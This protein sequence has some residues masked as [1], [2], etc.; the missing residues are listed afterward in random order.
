MNIKFGPAGMNN[1]FLLEKTN[2][3]ISYPSY[4]GNLNLDA[5][6]Y[7][8]GHGIR[9]SQKMANEFGQE[10]KKNSI[11]ISIHSPYYISLSSIEPQK[12]KNS[13]KYI[14]QTAQ[15]AKAMG[16]KRIVVHSGSCSKISRTHA[17]DL[18][19]DTINQ[20]LLT[21][22]NENLD[23]IIICPEVMGKTNQL[24]TVDE[25]IELS[26]LGDNVIPCVDFGHLNARSFGTLKSKS[27]YQI[28]FDKIENNLGNFKMKNLH[29]HFSKIEYTQPG[30]E[31]RHLTFE[32]KNFGPDFH[33]LAEILIKKS[34][35]PIIICESAGTQ[36]EDAI[37]MKQIYHCFLSKI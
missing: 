9:I 1:A 23:D 2:K 5:Y 32:D 22:K 31:K 24:G 30:G 13:V 6:E 10:C 27:D 28:V 11:Y 33:P 25:V 19:K 20:A 7:Q 16:A 21:L 14:L 36:V 12:R 8:C 15:I 37:T 29:I 17:L 35:S 18:A 4:I 34:A 26:K 3:L